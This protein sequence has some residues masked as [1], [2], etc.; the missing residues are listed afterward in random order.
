M[1]KVVER[2]LCDT[3][4]SRVA[5][6]AQKLAGDALAEIEDSLPR[7]LAGD[8]EQVDI[9]V[10]AYGRLTDQM[11]EAVESARPDLIAFDKDH[12]VLW[13]GEATKR[14][15]CSASLPWMKEALQGEAMSAPFSDWV[16]SL[17]PGR[18]TALA[19]VA[20]LRSTLH[21][22][23]PISR[24]AK[25]Q[26]PNWE[27]DEGDVVRFYRAVTAALESTELPL[28][29]IQ[30]VFGLNRTET[31]ALFGVRRQALEGWVRNRVPAEREPKLAT[32]GAI[33][34]LLSVQLKADR[35]AAVVRRPAPAHRGRS[36]LAAIE[37]G[38]EE[39][40]LETLRAGFDWSS[41]A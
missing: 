2:L 6:A 29:R 39:Q 11:L 9:Y 31:A 13:V 41:G 27:L 12:N 38:D 16:G 4:P 37:A 14:P 17:D 5:D 10:A 25:W 22:S 24:P 15:K 35:V 28:E 20:V 21:T 19:I 33:A 7:A 18:G 34:D 23:K 30:T 32:I 1:D 3:A 36:I 8:R 26:L 40:V